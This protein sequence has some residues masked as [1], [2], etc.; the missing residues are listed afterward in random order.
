MR[1][2]VK[3]KAACIW[4]VALL[5]CLNSNSVETDTKAMISN[6]NDIQIEKK[7]EASCQ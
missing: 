7:H 1:A 5:F 3:T 2:N 4:H 6:T